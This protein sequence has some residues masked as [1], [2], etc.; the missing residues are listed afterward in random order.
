MRPPQ[1]LTGKQVPLPKELHCLSAWVWSLRTDTGSQCRINA[2]EG[3]A[4]YFALSALLC[5]MNNLRHLWTRCPGALCPSR[6]VN[7]P[8]PPWRQAK[9]FNY[10]K[11]KTYF[12]PTSLLCR[13][14]KNGGV[15]F[16]FLLSFM[17]FI[18]ILTIFST[19]TT[20]G[21]FIVVL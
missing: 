12:L 4:I 2:N 6:V 21:D 9:H 17:R 18:T 16:I 7:K 14:L 19:V 8:K 10:T 11:W 1:A 3:L 13:S 20:D 5:T 15:F